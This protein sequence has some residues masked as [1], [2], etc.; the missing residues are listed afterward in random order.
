MRML[1][2]RMAVWT[3][4]QLVVLFSLGTAGT[5]TGIE[6]L[7]ADAEAAFERG[8]YKGT[9]K[10]AKRTLKADP[11][12]ARAMFL[13]GAAAHELER[14]DTAY[15]RLSKA[16]EFDPDFYVPGI[17]SRLGTISIEQRDWTSNAKRKQELL[18]RAI[19]HFEGELRRRP[20]DVDSLVGKADALTLNEKTDKAIE[21]WED[22]AHVAPY[23]DVPRVML[24]ALYSESGEVN[25]ALQHLA[26]IG[27][28]GKLV[29]AATASQAKTGRTRYEMIC[30]MAERAIEL[31]TGTRSQQAQRAALEPE[32]EHV[33]LDD[34]LGAEPPDKEMLLVS[35]VRQCHTIRK[36]AGLSLGEWEALEKVEISEPVL[37]FKPKPPFPDKLRGTTRNHARVV[38]VVTIRYD[39]S[40]GE[41]WVLDVE[42]TGYGVEQSAVH[43]VS[44]WRWDP[45]KLN[46]EPVTTRFTVVFE[47]SRG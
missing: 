8:D 26:R 9:M 45:A 16:L 47:Y 23:A 46:G 17:H 20:R 24:V 1:T 33:A 10:A 14:W 13:S 18:G 31:Q 27:D 34:Y 38:L 3:V 19:G 28:P 7:I 22:V 30:P 29:D 39:G 11:R 37:V 44:Q 5:E 42:P 6:A 40:V 41:V 12:N 4:L 32:P 21:A 2:Y 43:A 25:A 35:T 15:S 36:A